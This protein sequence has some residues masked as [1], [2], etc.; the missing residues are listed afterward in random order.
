M[1]VVVVIIAR[2]AAQ[3]IPA[4]HP[5]RFR[6]KDGTITNNMRSPAS[7]A[8]QYFLE[9]GTSTVDL[10]ALV[11]SA[12]YVKALNTVP[13]R[14]TRSAKS[15]AAPSSSGASVG[16]RTLN[17]HAVSDVDSSINQTARKVRP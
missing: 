6:S 3:A 10:N 14:P 2:V 9:R 5:V 7:P 4:F 8:D 17:L 11:G 16:A 1:I 15:R 13:T 12:A